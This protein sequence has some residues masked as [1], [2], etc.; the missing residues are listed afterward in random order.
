M[1]HYALQHIWKQLVSQSLLVLVVLYSVYRSIGFLLSRRGNEWGIRGIDD[2][3]SMPA[4]LL[5]GAIF[6][7]PAV[8]AQNTVIRVQENHADMYGLE[9][10][11]GILANPGQTLARDFQK[12]GESVLMDPDPNPVQV[13]LFYQ[14]PPVRDRIHLFLT[15]DPWSSGSDPQFVR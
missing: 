5:V 14:H 1:G 11:H 12:F 8:I 15:Y 9:V 6:G 4:L 13:F 7:F 3:A 2:W 10:T